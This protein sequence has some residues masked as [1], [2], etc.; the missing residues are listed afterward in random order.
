[1]QQCSADSGTL[2]CSLYTNIFDRAVT[3][4]AA[5]HSLATGINT[6]SLSGTRDWLLSNI[7]RAT[8]EYSY[9]LSS[10]MTSLLRSNFTIDN[11]I[12]KA[13][14][15]NPVNRWNIP[16]TNWYQS[17]LLLSDKLLV[18]AMITLNNGAGKVLRRRLMSFAPRTRGSGR[19]ELV[20]D[21]AAL[22]GDAMS[23]G[24]A[25]RLLQSQKPAPS[26]Y[27]TIPLKAPQTETDDS[28]MKNILGKFTQEPRTGT[29]PGI[30][31]N[32]DVAY[33][34]TRVF[35]AQDNPSS[36]MEFIVYGRFDEEI[37]LKNAL[38]QIGTEFY[39]RM[40]TNMEKFCPICEKIVPVF[41]NFQKYG[42]L[43]QERGG[44]RLLAEKDYTNGVVYGT[45]SVL[46]VYNQALMKNTSQISLVDIQR[47]VFNPEF[48]VAWNGTIADKDAINRFLKDLA[49]K[50][51]I[52]G[53]V[54]TLPSQNGNVG[55]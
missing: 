4:G 33:T 9:S 32:V 6:T 26:E 52:I 7:L 50:Q 40:D 42:V 31:F 24:A 35:G 23:Q 11:R 5:V 3:R 18:V 12:N 51:F 28:V 13:W 53:D 43:Q 47:A 15:V 54:Q 10:N 1:M 38:K 36:V 27:I 2:S 25:R 8:D 21:S 16:M 46:L 37:S 22:A 19:M 48:T 45:F 30:E 29:L 17:D 14:L 49:D 55:L 44:R 41:N 20:S 39:R 34:I